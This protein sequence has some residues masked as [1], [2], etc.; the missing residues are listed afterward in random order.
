M[1]SSNNT[2]Y[3]ALLLATC[4][5]GAATVAAETPEGGHGQ[6]A[7]M[8][9]AGHGAGMHHGAEG[10]P[11]QGEHGGCRGQRGAQHGGGH[12]HGRSH[13][14]SPSWK[15]TLD[16]AQ[17][18][19]LDRLHVEY[20]RAKHPAKARSEALEMELRALATTSQPDQAAMD[21]KI[22]ELLA[23]KR[24]LLRA[25]YGYLAA[26]RQVLTAEQQLSFDMEAMHQEQGHGGKRH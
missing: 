2:M 22:D 13:L 17:K 9:G 5:G 14:Y 10:R 25:K 15:A 24:E 6:H 19:Q 12:G 23:V 1:L 21:A 16:D 4:L 7:A 26:Q 11:G 8:H 20:A 18:Q 3:R